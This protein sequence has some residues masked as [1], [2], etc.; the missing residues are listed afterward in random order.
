MSTPAQ[1]RDTRFDN[2]RLS[3]IGV[4]VLS[5]DDLR[6]RVTAD[7]LAEAERVDFLIVLLVSEGT[8]EHLI[9]FQPVRLAPG[10]VVVVRPG[11]VQQWRLHPGVHGQLL[12]VDTRL[13]QLAASAL[14]DPAFQ[15]LQIDEWPAAFVL[16]AED[17]RDGEA[18]TRVLE[19]QLDRDRVDD[20]SARLARELFL[21]LMVLLSRAARIAA[22]ART[23]QERLFQRLQ[24]DLDA[25]VNTRPTVDAIARR[26][27]VS[28]S[29]LSRVC[30]ERVGVSAKA[31]I[32]RRTALEAQRLLVH[33]GAT[34]T[35]IGEALGFSEPTNFL[36]FFK[37]VVGM[38]PDA[39]RRLYRP[40]A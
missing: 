33:T 12:L 32:D 34:T 18:L 35:A 21:S 27:R 14:A 31:F 38:T 24:R 23:A 36:K 39:F 4:E 10:A 28:P 1:V 7:R 19:R 17:Q 13:A 8:C 15:L 11:Q 3:D 30:L 37:R 29:T 25:S 9:D 22:P 26:L 5:L 20:V 40:A 6:S 16:S 2:A